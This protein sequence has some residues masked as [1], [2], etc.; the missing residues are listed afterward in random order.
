MIKGDK[1]QIGTREFVFLGFTH[2]VSLRFDQIVNEIRLAL[3][4]RPSEGDKSPEIIID[5]SFIRNYFTADNWDIIFNDCLLCENPAWV[6]RYDEMGNVVGKYLNKFFTNED[7]KL[8]E[9]E[10]AESIK[11][12]LIAECGICEDTKYAIELAGEL[13]KRLTESASGANKDGLTEFEHPQEFFHHYM[14]GLYFDDKDHFF[15]MKIMIMTNC[16][17]LELNHYKETLQAV[18]IYNSMLNDLRKKCYEA[19]GMKQDG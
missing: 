1:I 10:V 15:D 11:K 14:N 13:Y 3:T 19:K 6:E 16:T 7:S 4:I 18:T 9:P 12:K 5:E 17:P 8:I 2:K